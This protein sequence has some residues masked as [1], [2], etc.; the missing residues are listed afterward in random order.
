[1]LVKRPIPFNKYFTLGIRVFNKKLKL[2][3]DN[4]TVTAGHK[5]RLSC[6]SGPKTINSSWGRKKEKITNAY[7]T[8]AFVRVA[9]TH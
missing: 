3:F 6:R 1:L 8:Q 2:I 5:L 9:F 4:G 7:E